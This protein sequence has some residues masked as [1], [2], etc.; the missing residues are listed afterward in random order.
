MLASILMGIAPVLAKSLTTTAAPIV[1]EK[2]KSTLDLSPEANENTIIDNILK[3]IKDDGDSLNKLKQF[4]NDF[5]LEMRK[6]EVQDNQIDA[7]D[8]DSARKMQISTR[9]LMPIGIFIFCIS[10]FF[11]ILETIELTPEAIYLILGSLMGY[12][13][14]IVTFYY[15]SSDSSSKK[16]EFIEQMQRNSNK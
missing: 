7:G 15:G 1:L 6:L 16:N 13:A 5:K 2:I 3:A 4:E 12:I 8:R 11:Y 14:S 9:S 10:A